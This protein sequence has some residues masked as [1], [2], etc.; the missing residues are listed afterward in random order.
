MGSLDRGNF[1]IPW[2]RDLDLQRLFIVQLEL[3][4]EFD[5]RGLAQAAA[6][7]TRAANWLEWALRSYA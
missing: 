7:A 4:L 6:E 2:L 3:A 1:P 5:R